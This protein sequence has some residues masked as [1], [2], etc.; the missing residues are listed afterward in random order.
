MGILGQGD[1]KHPGRKISRLKN[2]SSYSKIQ[3]YLERPFLGSPP[4]HLEQDE[5]A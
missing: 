5:L 2:S 3:H 1:K 4:P